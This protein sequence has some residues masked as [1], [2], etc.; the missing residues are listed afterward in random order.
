MQ[1][2]RRGKPAVGTGLLVRPTA[3]PAD[4]GKSL[5][6]AGRSAIASP[7]PRAH[8][9]KSPARPAKGQACRSKLDPSNVLIVSAL[10]SRGRLL[11]AE[12]R[13]S[14]AR[15]YFQRALDTA[16]PQAGST[17]TGRESSLQ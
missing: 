9:P 3:V 1:A 16:Q 5:G 12:R 6:P 10:S 17:Y 2:A 15:R 14:E 4:P 11:Q 13:Y 8:R 7:R